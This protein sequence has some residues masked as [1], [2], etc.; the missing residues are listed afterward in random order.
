MLKRLFIIIIVCSFVV[1]CVSDEKKMQKIIKDY[2]Y[3]NLDDYKSYEPIEFHLSDS[4]FSDWTMDPMLPTL[5][6]YYE[7]YS[8]LADSLQREQ[9][10][11][12]ALGY[13]TSEVMETWND[14]LE[15]TFFTKFTYK[16]LRDSIKD[17]Y[18]SR[19]I[20]YGIDHS[21]RAK[22]RLGGTEKREYQFIINPSTNNTMSN[23]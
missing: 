13:S 21:F 22:N 23:M 20:G 8:R 15:A 6:E 1:S 3:E 7:K 10:L 18:E 2:L 19:F 5:D 11:K 9:R 4:L 16:Q 12:S 14:Y 17:H